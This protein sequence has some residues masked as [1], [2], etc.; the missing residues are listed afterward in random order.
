MFVAVVFLFGSM[1]YAGAQRADIDQDIIDRIR[2]CETPQGQAQDP[3][4]R[5]ITQSKPPASAAGCSIL[6]DPGGCLKEYAISLFDKTILPLFAGILQLSSYLFE[7]T[8][9]IGVVNFGFI[10]G[11]DDS[12]IENVWGLVRDILNIGV[13]FVLLYTAIQIIIGR[14]V[15]VKKVIAGV[16]LFGV[17]TNFS[18][19]F[20]KAAVDVSN[21]IALEFYNQMRQVSINEIS[22]ENGLGAAIVNTTGLVGLYT[23]PDPKNNVGGGINDGATKSS[24][25]KDSF[26]FRIAMIF[27]FIAVSFIFVQAAF[28]FLARTLTLIFLLIFSPLMF[29]GGIFGAIQKWVERWHKEFIGQVI[30]APLFF[31]LL[32]VALV[33][34]NNLKGTVDSQLGILTEQ[35][36]D[37]FLP[38]VVILITT[39]LMVFAFALALNQAKEWAG[40]AG[41]V[42]VKW[43]NKFSGFVAGVGLSGT[44]M[45]LRTVGRVAQLDKVSAWA[46]DAKGM[47]GTLARS[48]GLG[49]LENRTFD[50]RNSK[51]AGKVGSGVSAALGAAGVNTGG[52]SFGPGSKTTLK[53]P[54][55]IAQIQEKYDKAKKEVQKRADARAES[56]VE[57]MLKGIEEEQEEK[58]I[59]ADYSITKDTEVAYIGADGNVVKVARPDGETDKAWS[60]KIKEANAKNKKH[61]EFLKQKKLEEGAASLLTDIN[62]RSLGFKG[63][64][65]GLGARDA[66]AE[67]QARQKVTKKF[68]ESDEAKLKDFTQNLK[69][70]TDL[71]GISED[72]LL[73]IGSSDVLA[74][75][76]TVAEHEQELLKTH[77]RKPEAALDKS[78]ANYKTWAKTKRDI[79]KRLQT[80]KSAKS[81]IAELNKKIEAEK[82]KKEEDKGKDTK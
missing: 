18:L 43:G 19:F 47:Q 28:L 65:L 48:I 61:L 5:T 55:V 15:E 14:G 59:R 79:E 13:I 40:S 53:D 70:Y 22:F 21:V 10:L 33:V 27:V 57:K 16:I 29:A 26:M 68:K 34:M 69:T 44:A 75:W 11:G 23:P 63:G 31:I 9:W 17:L 72:D 50:V 54:G 38:L 78:D 3:D 76:S 39:G 62:K 46:K 6:S 24:Y 45:G 12:W 25:L 7:A 41:G 58:G 71:L 30:F 51:I 56:R 80:A 60:E 66:I 82:K 1:Q 4:C 64:F 81:K 20:T 42:A 74:H 73:T 2:Y 52:V 37:F 32:Y 67:Y 8:I 49:T 77:N 36:E 35:G